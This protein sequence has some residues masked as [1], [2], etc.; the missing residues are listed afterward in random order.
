HDVLPVGSITALR[1]YINLPGA[2]ESVE[3]VHEKS[4]HER[5]KRLINRGE[6][7]A[8]L[9]D[10]V[11][12]DPD[13]NLGNVRQK[14]RNQRAKL[15]PFARCIQKCFHVLREKRDILACPVFKH[16]RESA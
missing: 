12:I 16:K 9:D 2:A 3:V 15:G 14:C 7:D 5:L 13:E 4:A 11:T 10:F 6:I 1:L 8:L